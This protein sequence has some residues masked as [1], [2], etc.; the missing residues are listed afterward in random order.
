M[1]DKLSDVR[2]RLVNVSPSSRLDLGL[3]PQAVVDVVDPV[4]SLTAVGPLSAKAN[5]SHSHPQAAQPE[6]KER[7]VNLMSA[8]TLLHDS[9]R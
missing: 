1:R 8:V 7:Y 5:H 2:R 4:E 6:V 3:H 9:A